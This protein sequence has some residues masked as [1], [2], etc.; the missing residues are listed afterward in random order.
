MMLHKNNQAS[1]YKNRGMTLIESVIVMVI[2]S[3]GMAAATYLMITVT[4]SI[5]ENGKRMTATYLAQECAELTR[6]VRDS[7]WKQNLPWDCAFGHTSRPAVEGDRYLI[8]PDFNTGFVAGGYDTYSTDYCRQSLG[9]RLTETLDPSPLGLGEE[10]YSA[11]GA[12]TTAFTRWLEIVKTEEDLL[13][14]ECQ[15]SWLSGTDPQSV[16]LPLV[17][18]NWK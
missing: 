15:V 14:F 1:L 8:E 2:L 17:L 10:G 16:I 9:V 18:T 11:N 7:A 5:S 6:N 13:E 4:T 3:L 12:E